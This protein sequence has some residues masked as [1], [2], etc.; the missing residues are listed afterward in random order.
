VIRCAALAASRTLGH[1]HSTRRDG[2]VGPIRLAGAAA[3]R[4]ALVRAA[5][6]D[7]DAVCVPEQVHGARV[8]VASSGGA[9]FPATDALVTAVRGVPLFAQGADC[10]LVLL[11]DETAGVLGV[12][13]SGWRGTVAR[14]AA[15]AVDAMR[16]LGASAG[17]ID[18]AVF[19][20]IG[21]CCFE[22]GLDVAASFD[23]AFGAASRG[24]FA[25]GRAADKRMLALAPAIASALTDV[26][27]P[28]GRVHVVDGCTA[29]G[30]EFF[31]HRAS[32]G[33]PERHGLAA[34]LL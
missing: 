10:P 30:E 3:G 5:G 11:V 7:P 1:A 2:P 28:R 24:W 8:A 23:G 34:V 33:G 29:C 9:A 15:S 14:I 31:S 6:G 17:R 12:A 25:A 13:H 4:A 21:P 16:G 26:G 22:V 19:P 20:G 27:V 18:A 32:R